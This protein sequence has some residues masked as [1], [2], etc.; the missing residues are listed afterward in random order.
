MFVF[1]FNRKKMSRQQR[2]DRVAQRKKAFLRA[3]EEA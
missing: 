2:N 1:R 3:K